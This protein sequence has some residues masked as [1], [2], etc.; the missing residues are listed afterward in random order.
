MLDLITRLLAKALAILHGYRFHVEWEVQHPLGRVGLRV[1]VVRRKIF[2]RF[3]GITIG[4]TLV[5]IADSYQHCFAWH[6]AT[7]AHQWRLYGVFFPFLY[8][9]YSF[10]SWLESGDPYTGNIFEKEARKYEQKAC[11]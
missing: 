1:Y 4:R 8:L 2:G 11:R 7:H 5:T 6:E 9:W 10:V 3:G